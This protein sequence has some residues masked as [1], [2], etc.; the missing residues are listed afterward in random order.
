MISILSFKVWVYTC[1]RRADKKDERHAKKCLVVIFGWWNK[2]TE[3]FI[4]SFSVIAKFSTLIVY[5][6]PIINII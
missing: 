4:F 5:C 1:I 6:F 2:V 3:I